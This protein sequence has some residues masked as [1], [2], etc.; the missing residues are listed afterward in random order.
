MHLLKLSLGDR[1]EVVNKYK[2]LNMAL[3]KMH[4]SKKR[5]NILDEREEKH[6]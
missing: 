3:S 5:E 2:V 6:L 4:E 1:V